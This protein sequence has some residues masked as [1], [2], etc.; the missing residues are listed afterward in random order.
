MEWTKAI[1][2]AIEYI[3]SNL[4]EDISA[5]DAARQVN[6]SSFYFQKGF[7]ML[8]GYTVSEYIRNRRLALAAGE[9]VNGAKVIDTAIKY[10][11]DSPDSFAKAFYRFHGVTPSMVQKNS[12]MIKAFAPLKIT[13]TLKGG[14]TMDYRI[15]KKDSFTVLGA[16][17]K[18]SYENAT[19]DISLFWDEHYQKGNGKY[20][21]GMFGVCIDGEMQDSDF[22]YMIADIYNPA[23][24]IPDGFVTKT[25]PAFTWA[26]FP[27]KGAMPDALQDVNKKIFSEWLPAL[28]DYDIAAG[29]SV[30]MYDDPKQYPKG[31]EDENY[32]S[33]I[34]I[35][36]KKKNA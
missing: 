32:Y 25:I 20:V 10:C 11:Y 13:L 5:E 3:E 14:Y 16:M 35:P 18:F 9:L 33:E 22:D 4:T 29:Y 8:C 2:E 7:A 6:I 30:E 26:V 21:G 23:V 36:V 1:S 12:T 15:V 19:T 28:G 27:I 31:T 34:W 17:K 24:D